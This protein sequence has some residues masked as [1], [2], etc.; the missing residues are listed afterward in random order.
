ML[1]RS[2]L[3]KVVVSTQN[4]SFFTYRQKILHIL[5][6]VHNKLLVCLH[7]AGIWYLEKAQKV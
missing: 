2:E 4:L 6:L 1:S 7:G 3:G 5:L